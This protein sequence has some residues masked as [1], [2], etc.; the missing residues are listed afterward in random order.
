MV[1]NKRSYV[2]LLATDNYWPAVRV[3]YYSWVHYHPQSSF[4]L[5]LGKAV[6][7]RL[8]EYIKAS[9]VPCCSLSQLVGNYSL[10]DL[11]E[12]SHHWQFTF[13][14]LL[15]F[16]LTGFEKLI[17]LDADMLIM[18][19][20][21]TLFLHPH[22]SAVKAG[23][24]LHRHQDWQQ[25]N[26]GLMV[27]E[28]KAGL[29]KAIFTK[30]DLVEKREHYS[31][32]DLLH[33]YYSEWPEQKHLHLPA[34]YNVFAHHLDEYV[35]EVG[36]NTN[37]NNRNEL[38]IK[39]IHFPTRNRPW[40]MNTTAWV[41]VI[42]K[43]FFRGRHQYNQALLIYSAILA[44]LFNKNRPNYLLS[45]SWRCWLRSLEKKTLTVNENKGQSNK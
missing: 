43:N 27:V 10:P 42:L 45:S 36:L 37:F 3:L 18:G 35:K 31:D 16:E 12:D 22:L 28:P 7:T 8:E 14:K 1:K 32:Q 17:F 23:G 44:L 9:D 30:V 13:E 38:T 20:L 15:V 34:I 24:H 19:N 25:L 2:T 41:E 5:L 39:V 6:S 11:F 29:A 21:D 40:L 4:L 26:S 33:L